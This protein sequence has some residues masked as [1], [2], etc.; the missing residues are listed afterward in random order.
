[1]TNP[2]RVGLTGNEINEEEAKQ[3]AREFI[4]K[5]KELEIIS[6]GQSQNGNIEG[7]SFTLKRK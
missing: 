1:M 3:K 6:N 2:E 4:A 7:Y 5:E